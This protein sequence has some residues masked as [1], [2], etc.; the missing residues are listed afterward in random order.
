MFAI[1]VPNFF[2]SSNLRLR[3]CHSYQDQ[4]LASQIRHHDSSFPSGFSQRANS[5]PSASLATDPLTLSP[6]HSPL[7]TLSCCPKPFLCPRLSARSGRTGRCQ[8]CGEQYHLVVVWFHQTGHQLLRFPF[9]PWYT[10]KEEPSFADMLTT[11]RRVSYE[12]KS[13]QPL[14]EQ[15]GLKT[16]IAQVTELLSR[17][18]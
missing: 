4:D 6:R 7:A 16:W 2:S 8:R 10:K 9:R 17:T 11:L 5:L 14:P 18:G 15:S 12:E 1:L 3:K 13:P